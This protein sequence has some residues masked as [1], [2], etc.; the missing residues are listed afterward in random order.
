M[1]ARITTLL[2]LI[3]PASRSAFGNIA[4][5]DAQHDAKLST[6]R[7]HMINLDQCFSMLLALNGQDPEKAQTVAAARLNRASASK[8]LKRP[9]VPSFTRLATRRQVRYGG[10]GADYVP[11]GLWLHQQRAVSDGVADPAAS[12]CHSGGVEPPHGGGVHVGSYHIH[13]V[14]RRDRPGRTNANQCARSTLQVKWFW[15]TKSRTG[16]G[17]PV[18]YE[19]Q[20]DGSSRL[21][22][23]FPK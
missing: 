4:A 16:S 10:K 17:P 14:Y 12:K 8:P 20:V 5:K 1:L 22:A 18:P 21:L 23:G 7:H 9:T 2:R 19:G 13:F 15:S 6:M 11:C 3:R